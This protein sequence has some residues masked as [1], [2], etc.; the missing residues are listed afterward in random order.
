[1]T[2]TKSIHQKDSGH[3]EMPLPFRESL[4]RLAKNKIQALFRLDR[5]KSRLEIDEKY[6]KP[7]IAFMND[8]VDKGY[9]E[10]VPE[11]KLANR[12]EATCYIPH[13]S[14]TIPRN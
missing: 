6:R 1:M 9:A 2:A 10:L 14:S 12:M 7:Y 4:P 3:Y 5:L 11:D 8:L 13:H